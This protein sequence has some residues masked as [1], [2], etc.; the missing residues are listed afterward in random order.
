M[1]L[2]QMIYKRNS[3]RKYKDQL[4][5]KELLDK[6]ENFCLNIKPLY[7]DTFEFFND[8]NPNKLKGY[9]YVGSFKI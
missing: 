5:E 9:E 6:I 4:V 2:K 8:E 1:D 7:A 3:V